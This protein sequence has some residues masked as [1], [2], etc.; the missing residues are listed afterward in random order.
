MGILP[1]P[2]IKRTVE[3]ST[4]GCYVHSRH[5]QLVIEKGEETLGSVPIE[6]IGVLII[7]SP[8]ITMS[9]GLI[10]YL[11]EA[12]VALIFTDAKHLPSSI[13]I[14]FSGHST[15]TKILQQQVAISAPQ[16]KRMWTDIV[17]AKIAGQA[18]SL[19]LAG[20][21]GTG[22][23]EISKRVPSGDP[24]NLEAYAAR[25]YWQRLFGTDFR[26]DRDADDANKLLNYGYAV[27]RASMARAIVATGMHPAFGIHHTNQYNP[28]PLADDLMEPLRPF[29]DA[30]VFAI[31]RELEPD[32]DG[33]EPEFKL[34]TA[35][36]ADLLGVLGN[37]CRFD[38]RTMPLL[39][40]IGL[41]AA[42]VKQVFSREAERPLFPLL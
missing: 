27:L 42:S 22:L 23:L 21:D 5:K 20:K 10:S 40:A 41:Y 3:I 36:K 18:R 32:A 37:D 25:I 24:K 2:M 31:E 4:H 1:K 19:E 9:S 33:S 8:Q 16:R 17:S 29:I 11:A 38:K 12:N 30:R 34:D 6:D 35:V 26:R 7:D 15:Q 28:M 14:P 39:V 13:S